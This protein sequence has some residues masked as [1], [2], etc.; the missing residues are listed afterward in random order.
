MTRPDLEFWFEYGSTY[1][2][3]TV[4]R[5][6]AVTQARGI[7]VGW[8]P[9]LLMPIMI[10]QGMPQG[11][12]LPIPPNRDT[13]GATWNAA[14]NATVSLISGPLCTHRRTRFCQPELDV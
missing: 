1:T 10:D 4:A 12:F 2:Y 5:I 9:F 13:C 14:R 6:D 7:T 3:L 8:R 11:P